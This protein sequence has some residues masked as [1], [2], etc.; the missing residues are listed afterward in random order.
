MATVTTV[1]C[2][3]C[4]SEIATDNHKT[5]LEVRSGPIRLQGVKQIDL[6]PACLD[7]VLGPLTQPGPAKPAEAAKP[8]GR[9]KPA[10]TA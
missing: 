1:H 10:G 8:D 5:T 6:C 4:Q 7:A 9:S 2:D 3:R